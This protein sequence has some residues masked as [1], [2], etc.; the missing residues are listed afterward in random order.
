MSEFDTSVA[1]KAWQDPALALQIAG[2]LAPNITHTR[3]TLY[4][5]QR[6]TID[7]IGRAHV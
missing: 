7:K 4:G 5:P 6:S 1:Q 2:L 3:N